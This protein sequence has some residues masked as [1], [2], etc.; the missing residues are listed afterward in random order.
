MHRFRFLLV[1]LCTLA[2]A[3]VASATSPIDTPSAGGFCNKLCIIGYHCVPTPKGGVC[4]PGNGVAEPAPEDAT[5]STAST[6]S[7]GLVAGGAFCNKLCIIGYHCVPN[8]HGGVCV[9]GN[10]VAEPAPAT[11]T[12]S[13]ETAEM[14]AGELSAS[15]APPQCG[16]CTI[17]CPYGTHLVQKHNCDCVCVGNAG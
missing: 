10:G 15:K 7:A 2:F 1:A 16:A 13:T 17:L 9:P 5:A 12:D 11:S 14:I 8:A 4:V 6:D 3:G